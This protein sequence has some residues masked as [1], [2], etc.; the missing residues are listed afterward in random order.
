MRPEIEDIRWMRH[1][2]EAIAEAARRSRA[3]VVKPAGQGIGD[4]DDW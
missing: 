1:F 4:E 3:V 2:E